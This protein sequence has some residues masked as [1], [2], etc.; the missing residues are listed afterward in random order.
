M[1]ATSARPSASAAKKLTATSEFLFL[2][3]NCVRMS[4]PKPR[5]KTTAMKTHWTASGS[6]SFSPAITARSVIVGL[7]TASDVPCRMAGVFIYRL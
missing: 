1:A 6:P 5:K 3:A 2:R 4:M 7:A